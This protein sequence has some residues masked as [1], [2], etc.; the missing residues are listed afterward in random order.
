MREKNLARRRSNKSFKDTPDGCAVEIAAFSLTFS[1]EWDAGAVCVLRVQMRR[2]DLLEVS[3]SLR[4]APHQS[5]MPKSK[6]A[7]V[8][9][10]PGIALP[11]KSGEKPLPCRRLPALYG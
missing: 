7:E 3:K 6:D 9:M 10:C 8:Q 2:S 4:R 11:M 1:L 5:L